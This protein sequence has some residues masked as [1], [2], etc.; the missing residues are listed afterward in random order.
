MKPVVVGAGLGAGAAPAD[1]TPPVL[2]LG[3][4][5]GQWLLLNAEPA[6]ID[7]LRSEPRLASLARASDTPRTVVLTDASVDQTTGLLGLRH[8]APLLLYATPA[9]FEGLAPA[10]PVVQRACGLQWKVLPVAGDSRVAEFRIDSMPTLQFT[11]IAASPALPTARNGWRAADSSVGDG[12][13]LVVRDRGTGGRLVCATAGVQLGD[14]GS[15]FLRGADC[16]VVNG[17][18]DDP[19]VLR[20]LGRLPA[21]HKLGCVADAV[22]GARWLGLQVAR[23]GMEIRL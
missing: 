16:V 23:I 7:L 4:D 13:A 3:D 20:G 11:A 9:V 21:R 6:A 15:E 1:T 12:I 8:G 22:E 14:G 18:L 19:A 10:L 17:A 2:A 5:A